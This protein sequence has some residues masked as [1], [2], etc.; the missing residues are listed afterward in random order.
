MQILSHHYYFRRMDLHTM[1]NPGCMDNHLEPENI[2]LK[3]RPAFQIISL[4]I[5]FRQEIDHKSQSL[6]VFHINLI[7]VH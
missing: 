7:L 5:Q 3:P 4:I 6:A 2:A 1:G